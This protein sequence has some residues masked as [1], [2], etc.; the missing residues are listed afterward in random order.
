[1]NKILT[2][3]GTYIGVNEN[4]DRLIHNKFC[5]NKVSV[6][7]NEDGK[8]SLLIENNKLSIHNSEESHPLYIS[9]IYDSDCKIKCSDSPT[10]FNAKIKDGG[11]LNIIF[12]NKEYLF[13]KKDLTFGRCISSSDTTDFV[14]DFEFMYIN[15]IKRLHSRIERLEYIF[16][17]NNPT[18][19]VPKPIG[20]KGEYA[21]LSSELLRA[22][23][24]LCEENN[25]QYWLG[26]GTL[27]GAVRNGGIIP[28]DDD[29]DIC[30]MKDDFLKLQ[31][32]MQSKK[33]EEFFLE[34]SKFWPLYKIRSEESVFNWK[35]NKKYIPHID[36]FCF[37]YSN[38]DFNGLDFAKNFNKIIKEK[39]NIYKSNSSEEESFKKFINYVDGM[40]MKFSSEKNCGTIFRGY[41]FPYGKKDSC[42]YHD[43][44]DIFPLKKIKF[45]N[46]YVY[47]PN[48]YLKLLSLKYGDYT[49]YPQ[50]FTKHL[51][52]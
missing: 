47:V 23:T 9:D 12:D 25:I 22:V 36:V 45:D 7:F 30:M 32:H 38:N 18:S 28:W 49:E 43:Y 46:F 27:L 16:T 15:E 50:V 48:A 13:A 44:Q 31:S 42:D 14:Y 11:K 5:S 10:Y 19:N 29:V 33:Y 41:E 6:V 26:Y 1:M 4:R 2:S 34:Y 37:Y 8:V 35:T 20:I 51:K 39:D 17:I 3:Y 24:Q 52:F 40:N 21:S